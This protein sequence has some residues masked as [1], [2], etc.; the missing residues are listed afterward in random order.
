MRS[1]DMNSIDP[2]ICDVIADLTKLNHCFP[3]Q[4]CYGHFLYQGQSDPANCHPLPPLAN[5]AIVEYRIA[6]LAVCIEANAPGKRFLGRLAEIPALDP[7]YVQ[8]GSTD[9]FWRRQVNSFVLQVEPDRYTTEDR[10][11]IFKEEAHY[12]QEVRGR[13]YA[14]V[15]AVIRKELSREALRS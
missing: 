10:I 13:F 11:S 12:L 2:P 6:Y 8:F 7:D 9:W 3:L 1:L 5:K 14:A 4:S 15:R